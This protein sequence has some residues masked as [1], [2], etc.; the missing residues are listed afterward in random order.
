MDSEGF[1][2]SVEEKLKP[3]APVLIVNIIEKQLAASNATR[4]ILTPHTAMVF[5]KKVTDALEIFLGPQG[6]LV[7]KK[8]MLKELKKYAPEHFEEKVI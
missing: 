7:V 6:K 4:Q 8:M 5:I 2:N 1:V 3:F